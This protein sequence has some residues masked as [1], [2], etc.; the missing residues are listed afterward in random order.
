MTITNP[1]TPAARRR[2]LILRSLGWSTIA[3]PAGLDMNFAIGVRTPDPSAC[4]D[5]ARK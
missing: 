4:I 3:A 5:V 1:S 2:D